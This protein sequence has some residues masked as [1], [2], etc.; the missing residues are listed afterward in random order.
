MMFEHKK[1]YHVRNCGLLV[2]VISSEIQAVYPSGLANFIAYIKDYA[3]DGPSQ[4][5][6]S[7]ATEPGK[8]NRIAKQFNYCPANLVKP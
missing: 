1:F 5:F 2:E 3:D 6:L 8:I 7:K 4:A